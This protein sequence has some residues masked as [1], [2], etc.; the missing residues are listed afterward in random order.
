MREESRLAGTN[1]QTGISTTPAMIVAFLS[2][3]DASAALK[4]ILFYSVIQW[5][6]DLRRE[7]PETRRPLDHA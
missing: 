5:F 7:E 4:V 6:V 3:D 1:F 2:G